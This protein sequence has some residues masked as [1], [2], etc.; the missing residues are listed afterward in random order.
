ML[1]NYPLKCSC[2]KKPKL[3]KNEFNYV[4][5]YCPKGCNKTFFHR[6]PEFALEAWNCMATRGWDKIKVSI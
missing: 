6:L 4:S 3:M 1:L 5:Y 2:G